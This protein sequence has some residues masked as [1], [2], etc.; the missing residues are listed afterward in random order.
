M[1]TSLCYFVVLTTTIFYFQY[2]CRISTTVFFPKT[3]VA[4]LPVLANESYEQMSIFHISHGFVQEIHI[5]WAILISNEFFCTKT[6]V[7]FIHRTIRWAILMF[8]LSSPFFELA[9]TRQLSASIFSTRLL[10]KQRWAANT[11]WRSLCSSTGHAWEQTGSTGD[12]T[13]KRAGSCSG[14]ATSDRLQRAGL[15]SMR[16]KSD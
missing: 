7:S 4:C 14:M 1:C 3:E 5:R 6:R 9:T 8:S 15:A 12:A 11:N 13:S 2:I 10:E 16:R